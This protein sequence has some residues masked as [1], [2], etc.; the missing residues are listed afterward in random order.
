[1]TT[2][3]APTNNKGMSAVAKSTFSLLYEFR[4]CH[5]GNLQAFATCE[6]SRAAGTSLVCGTKT[7]PFCGASMAG[8]CR[9]LVKT[10]PRRRP[11]TPMPTAMEAIACKRALLSMRS[12]G[13]G[14][15]GALEPQ[16]QQILQD[17]LGAEEGQGS[18]LALLLRL[19]DDLAT[20]VKSEAGVLR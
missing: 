11:A 9:V 3:I 6:V 4:H 16:L 7:T 8:L 13:E 17:Q 19:F 15:V 1:M 10:G 12:K 2:P 20:D 18:A 14:E 5:R